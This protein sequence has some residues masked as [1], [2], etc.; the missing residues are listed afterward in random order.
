MRVYIPTA[1]YS[2]VLRMPWECDKCSLAVSCAF[3]EVVL[4]TSKSK[5]TYRDCRRSK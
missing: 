4:Y 5:R 2:L 3:S 1:S